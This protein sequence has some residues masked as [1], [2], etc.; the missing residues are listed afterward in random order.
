MPAHAV[1]HVAD[2]LALGGVHEDGGGGAGLGVEILDSAFDLGE[3]MAVDGHHTETEIPQLG[4]HG[5]GVHNILGGTV[6]LQ[7]VQVDDDAE[8]IQLVVS[9][10][11][12]GFPHFALGDLAVTQQGV[13]PHI[14][15]VQILGGFGH[16]CRTGDIT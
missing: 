6:D 4:V 8:V 14:V 13:H 11:E 5:V 16:A 2:A 12:E 1:L 15:L 7:T 10:K 3:V 9:G